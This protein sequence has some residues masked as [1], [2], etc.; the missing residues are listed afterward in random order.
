MLIRFASRLRRRPAFV[1]DTSPACLDRPFRRDEDA[2]HWVSNHD[3][4]LFAC[5]PGLVIS[6][7]DI[8]QHAPFFR[9]HW[10]VD[11]FG[12]LAIGLQRRT[13]R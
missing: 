3:I 5:R 11:H 1:I 10:L 12:K 9:K 2:I 6:E 8:N 13:Y 4:H 7:L